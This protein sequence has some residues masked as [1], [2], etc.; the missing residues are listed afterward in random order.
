[1]QKQI[2]EQLGIDLESKSPEL[3]QTL[4]D[5]YP[6]V[7]EQKVD[8]S[9]PTDHGVEMEINLNGIHKRPY[10]YRV[11]Y[12]YREKVLQRIQ[13]MREEGVLRPS[14]SPFA[15]PLVAVPKKDGR[16]R[17]CADFRALN[18][19]TIPDRYAMPRIDDIKMHVVG[20]V[21]STLDLREGFNQVPIKESDIFKTAM[22]TPWGTFE[23][24]R[25]PFGL[26]NAP[27]VF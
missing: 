21:F 9:K 18:S 19:V 27:A 16:M 10:Q 7:F 26:R 12:A 14:A 15:A 6:K 1:L 13:E 23:Y 2:I 4:R 8:Y 24:T 20:K 17:I 25:M 5:K 11:P 22:H 3:I